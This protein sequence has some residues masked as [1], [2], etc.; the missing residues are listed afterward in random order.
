MKPLVKYWLDRYF[1]RFATKADIDNLYRQ[2]EALL[3]VRGVIGPGLVL[4]PLRRWAL[5]PDAL[6]II[7]RELRAWERPHVLEFGS[8]SSTIAIAAALKAR[9]AG[10]LTS[11]EHDPKF[12][13]DVIRRLAMANCTDYAEV[14]IVPVKDH[15]GEEETANF[16]SYDL[17]GFEAEFDIA[18]IDG[19]PTVFGAGGRYVPLNWVAQRLQGNRVAFLDD[20]NRKYERLL[21]KRLIEDWPNI[22][23]ELIPAEKGLLR[24]QGPAAAPLQQLA[25][26]TSVPR[27]RHD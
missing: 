25:H 10:L 9:G 14:M 6:A 20:A 26:R 15:L 16:R 27:D 8:G 18:L 3:E 24:M 13:K 1:G 11:I 2:L 7:L 17:N 19:P 4:G 23:T 21:T 12:A 5:S 22:E